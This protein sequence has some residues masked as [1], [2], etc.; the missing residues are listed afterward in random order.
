M[1]PI[2]DKIETEYVTGDIS[3]NDIV[4]KYGVSKYAVCQH[5]RHGEWVKKR[6]AYRD[7]TTAKAI[8]K[9]QE[10]ILTDIEDGTAKLNEA[11]LNLCG[12]V[13][14]KSREELEPIDAQRITNMYQALLPVEEDKTA[15]EFVIK[16]ADPEMDEYAD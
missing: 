9:A 2:W 10:K 1:K 11:W 6:A 3:I 4:K 16:F 5:S 13:L 15:S 8:Q 7:D 12:Y 14:R